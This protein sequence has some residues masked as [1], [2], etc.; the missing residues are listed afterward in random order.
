MAYLGVNEAL[1]LLR[2]LPMSDRDKDIEILTLRH[3]ITVLDRQLG[4]R[5]PRFDAGDRTYRDRSDRPLADVLPGGGERVPRRSR[6]SN[7]MVHRRR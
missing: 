4:K 6:L 3:Q 5:R 7:S 1:A 2:L